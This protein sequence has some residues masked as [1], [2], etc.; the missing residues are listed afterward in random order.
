MRDAVPGGQQS[1]QEV[2][3]DWY[4]D[5]Y[6]HVAATADGSFFERFMHRA[7]ER[8]FNGADRF[9]EVLEVG[10]NRGEHVPYVRHS[11][12]RYLLTDLRR[13]V[14]LE[15]LESDARI[16]PQAC[17][18]TRMSFESGRFDRVISTCLLH[19]VGSPLDALSEMRRVARPAGGVVT[20]L[21]PTDPGLAY[22]AGRALTSVRAA[23]K[24]GIA[25]MQELVHAIDHRNHF[26][27]VYTQVR[28]VFRGDDVTVDWYP[29]RAPSVE[30]NAF[31]V[32][33]ARLSAAMRP[34]LRRSAQQRGQR[35]VE[36]HSRDRSSS[37]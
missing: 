34:P 1:A 27:S 33:H 36:R 6:S 20:I 3:D 30:L 26:R 5:H 11:Y 10:G 29:W 8:R 14:V 37:R 22:R 19:H 17:D 31:V 24:R 15:A 9:P 4:R 23:R 18:V 16:E 12:D 7:M 35:P 2:L 21:V 28:H 13:P 25:T 32:I